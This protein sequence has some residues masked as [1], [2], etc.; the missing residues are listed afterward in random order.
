MDH[1]DLDHIWNLY[2]DDQ[3]FNYKMIK[4]FADQ[5]GKRMKYEHGSQLVT[6]G[7]E[8]QFVYFI[9]S[10]TVGGKKLFLD[11]SEYSYFEVDNQRG[12]IGLLELLAMK[13]HYVV[14]I[15]CIT[16]VEVVRIPSALIYLKIMEDIQLLRSCIRLV[17]NDLYSSSNREGR[18]F[19][20]KG[21]DRLRLHLLRYYE[22]SKT[23]Q[24]SIIIYNK[25][26]SDLAAQIGL[27]IRTVSRA[28]KLMTEQEEIQLC[29][30]K[31]KISSQNYLNI[32]NSINNFVEFDADKKED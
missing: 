28:L 4:D 17:A 26:Q 3:E 15:R 12:N 19:H 31:I 11:G 18:L 6:A 14:T 16:D 20:L 22:Q 5:N 23:R 7:D 27:S 13:K 10:G 30:R 9:V 1:L 25:T 29:G 32:V 2:N 8:P 24:D 21:V